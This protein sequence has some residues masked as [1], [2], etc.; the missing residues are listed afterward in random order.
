MLNVN[1]KQRLRRV[2]A[3]I[4]RSDEPYWEVNEI[5][6]NWQKQLDKDKYYEF[7]HSLCIILRK[8]GINLIAT[9]IEKKYCYDEITSD[10]D[11]DNKSL[12]ERICDLEDELD[13]Y[14]T[15]GN[16]QQVCE[17]FAMFVKRYLACKEHKSVTQREAAKNN[18]NDIISELKMQPFLP[19][20]LLKYI[21]DFDDEIVPQYHANTIIMSQHNDNYIGNVQK[22]GTGINI[23][24]D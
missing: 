5:I 10:S 17:V 6:Q 13:K 19:T 23:N 24:K 1:E 3:R 8:Q 14:K 21:N 2:A 9:Y 16:N 11:D 15:N 7:L 12:N 20:E 22:G 4:K 18:I